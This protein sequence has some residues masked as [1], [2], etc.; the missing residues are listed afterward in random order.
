MSPENYIQEVLAKLPARVVQVDSRLYVFIGEDS[1]GKADAMIEKALKAGK[2]IYEG[3]TRKWIEHFPVMDFRREG[4][5]RYTWR[6]GDTVRV[7]R[8]LCVV[9]RDNKMVKTRLGF[10]W[11]AASKVL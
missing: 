6:D 5:A 9:D 7:E 10:G 8:V 3:G 2:S 11:R 1:F 4:S